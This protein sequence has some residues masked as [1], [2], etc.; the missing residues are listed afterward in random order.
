MNWRLPHDVHIKLPSWSVR[1]FSHTQNSGST[2]LDFRSGSRPLSIIPIASA[3]HSSRWA[4]ICGRLLGRLALALFAPWMSPPWAPYTCVS[5]WPYSARSYRWLSILDRPYYSDIKRHVT[6]SEFMS[7]IANGNRYTSYK[8]IFISVHLLSWCVVGTE[9]R[10]T[11]VY[12]SACSILKMSLL[13]L[14]HLF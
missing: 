9:M 10:L 4:R 5:R 1:R 3:H 14:T 7:Q 13:F 2:L 6:L 8:D 12:L 11:V